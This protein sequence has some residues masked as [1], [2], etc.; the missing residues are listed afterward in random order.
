MALPVSALSS[1][2]HWQGP[3]LASSAAQGGHFENVPLGD[4]DKVRSRYKTWL[5]TFDHPVTAALPST[6]LPTTAGWTYTDINTATTPLFSVTL[7]ERCALIDPGTK[8]QAGYQLQNNLAVATMGVANIRTMGPLVGVDPVWDNKELIWAAR[9]GFK[10][11]ATAWDGMALLGVFVS[12]TSLLNNTT[13]VPSVSAGGF[14]FHVGITGALTFLGTQSAITAAGTSTG[15]SILALDTAAVFNWFDLGF[16]VRFGDSSAGTGKADY[17]V[18][19]RLVGTITTGLPTMATT[20]SNTIAVGNGAAQLT[21]LG[22][23]YI[24]NAVTGPG[25]TNTSS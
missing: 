22:I 23:E 17:Y 4:I 21:D 3:I 1:G 11:D 24:Y 6:P 16:R 8:A 5:E 15:V 12:D 18:N 9:V 20:Y 10:S 25:R 13:G 19:G 7:A 14:G 2:S